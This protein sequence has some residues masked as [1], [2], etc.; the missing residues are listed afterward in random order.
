MTIRIIKGLMGDLSASISFIG[1]S[2][3]QSSSAS[4]ALQADSLTVFTGANDTINIVDDHLSENNGGGI[5]Y[6]QHGIHYSEYRASD[7]SPFGSADDVVTHIQDLQAGIVSATN[8]R[9]SLPIAQNSTVNTPVNVAFNFDATLT[10]GVS[11]FWDESSFPNGVSV[12]L[13]DRRKISGIITQTGT[14]TIDYEVGNGLGTIATSVDI[15]V[16]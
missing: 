6:D 4:M 9:K 5:T 13:F 16:A 10:R 8:L 15:N 14:Y 2:S 3:D 1:V 11:Y 7:G 12:S